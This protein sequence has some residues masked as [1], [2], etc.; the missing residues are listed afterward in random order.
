LPD[1]PQTIRRFG[2]FG[3]VFTPNFLTIIGVIFFLRAGW[4]VGN[5][6]LVGGIMLVVLANAISFATSMSISAIA[7]N[8]NVKTGGA[9]YLI[10]RSLGLEIGGSI[11]IPLYFSQALSVALYIMGFTEALSSLLPL[12]EKLVSALVCLALMMLAYKGADVALKAQYIIMGIL[13]L[14]LL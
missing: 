5:T 10:S 6:G 4:A 12:P 11:G 9:Y 3:G 13:A 7:T 1:E 2:T 8:M 14:A